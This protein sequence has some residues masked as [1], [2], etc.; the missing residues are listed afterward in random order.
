MDKV[1][2]SAREAVADVPDGATILVGG[3]GMAGVP[4][5]LLRA[6]VEQ[7]PRDL[8]I[9]HNNA[10]NDDYGVGALFL[11]DRVRHMI[12]TFPTYEGNQHF[13]AAFKAGRVKLTLVPQGTLAERMRA[14]GAGLGGFYTP[15]GVGTKMAEGKEVRAIGGR[16]YVFET[17]LGADY[18]FIKAQ[19]GDR[20]GN[21]VYR[22]TARNF[23]PVMATAARVT[24][25]EVEELVEPGDIDPEVVVTPSVFVKR[26]VR[27]EHWEPRGTL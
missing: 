25:A 2:A 13:L 18:A 14:A 15:T 22:G 16:T 26:V 12:C 24:I 3:F 21:L 6:L 19:R 9:V 1:F 17:P 7:G 10:G 4:E 27:G 20:F 23:N 8:T 11:H 5:N